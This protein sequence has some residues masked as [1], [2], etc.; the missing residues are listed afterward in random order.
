MKLKLSFLL[1][2]S[3]LIF[4]SC[5]PSANHDRGTVVA[6]I[7][8][9]YLYSNDM[10]GV[11]PAGTPKKD[12]IFL[13]KN[14][15]DS[16]IRKQLLI[17]QAERN[18]TPKQR[19][20]SS[21][22]E[23]YKN[24]LLTYAYE[25]ELIKQK[26]DTIVTETE[27]STYYLLNKSSF[28]LRYN[29]VKA[30]YV[31]LNE[32][33]KELKRF[34]NLLSNKDTVMSNTIDFL[35]KQHALS[36]YIGDEI[37]IRFDDLLQQI[38]IETFNQELFLKNNSY[39]EIKDKPFVYLIRFKDYMISESISPLEMETENIRNI[40]IN[41]RKQSFLRSMHEELYSKALREEEFEIY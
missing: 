35:A 7:Y 9:N 4:S 24:S 21:K 6:K 38:P 14:Y 33:S 16:W 20:F 32:D 17:R 5:D 25:A 39:V 41:K 19:D 10:L 1:L 11:V 2:L 22:L 40:I 30:V 13:V 29:I 31:V 8:D 37:W 26:L 15:I 18:L 23:D 12:S 27:I 36:Y 34:R 3:V 28:Q